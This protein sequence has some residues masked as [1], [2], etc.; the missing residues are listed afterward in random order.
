LDDRDIVL[1]FEKLH[2]DV[3][4]LS[5]A[6][7]K[8]SEYDHA[9]LIADLQSI[10]LYER[11]VGKTNGNLETLLKRG[12]KEKLARRNFVVAILWAAFGQ[13]MFEP[14]TDMRWNG[15]CDFPDGKKQVF[16]I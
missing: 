12:M 4:L 10:N 8:D 7:Y 3:H 1:S 5:L 6:F 13:W 2:R 14:V 9:Q 16:N 11:I 15:E